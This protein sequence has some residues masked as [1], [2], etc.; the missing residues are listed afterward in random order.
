MK[1]LL[2]V[3]P[4]KQVGVPDSL[5]TSMEPGLPVI[6]AFALGECNRFI[7]CEDGAFSNLAEVQSHDDFDVNTF[8][9]VLC[10]TYAGLPAQMIQDMVVAVATTVDELLPGSEWRVFV[11]PTSAVLH[12]SDQG[13]DALVTLW[14]DLDTKKYM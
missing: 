6:P 8:T 2:S 5:Q 1:F 14:Q 11:T 7:G 10:E 3:P 4:K 13:D 12:S 9:E